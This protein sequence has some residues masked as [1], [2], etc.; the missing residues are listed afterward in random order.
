MRGSGPLSA[1]RGNPRGVNRRTRRAAAFA[2]VSLLALAAPFLGPAAPVP[3]AAVAVLAAF[4][5]REGRLFELFARPGDRRDRR[6]N[7]LAGF[8][9]GA[10]GLAVFASIPSVSLSPAVFAAAVLVVGVGNLGTQVAREYTDEEFLHATGF[11]LLG[12]L[13]G[14]LGLVVVSVGA[15]KPVRLPAFVFLAASGALSAALLRSVLLERDDPVVMIS[16]G[17]LCWLFAVLVG[18]VTLAGIGVALAV[19]AALGYV[20]YAL[21]TASVAG[22]LTGV[23]LG[24]V[25]IVLGG[26]GWFAALIAFYAVGGLASKFRFEEK[27][28]RGVAQE[29]EGARGTGNVLANS[30]VALVAVVGYA[31][32]D[33]A[34]MPADPFV[35]AFAGAVATAMADTLS[36]EIGGLFD[37]PRLVTTLERVPPGTDGA[38]TLQ[39]ELAGIA[40]AALVGALAAVGMPVGDPLVG[41]GVVVAA[42]FAG[43]TVDSL[44]GALVEGDRIG[45]QTVNFLAT[46]SGALVAVGLAFAVVM[47]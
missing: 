37:D 18:D 1:R 23:L 47:A 21:G 17:L 15:G 28:E 39:G 35:F 16:V 32:T 3:F 4:V 13:G 46:L 41:G 38:V 5:V 25:T 36:S 12:S 8:A 14:L 29:N 22:M 42:G 2:A 7:G 34:A 20:S 45:N 24:L 9:L 40:G 27:A 30:A 31:A 19:T 44:L 33:H 6:L 10:T 43:M 11:V 26:F